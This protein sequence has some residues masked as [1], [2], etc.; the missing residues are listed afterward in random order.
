MRSLFCILLLF[1]LAAPIVGTYAGLRLEKRRVKKEVKHRLFAEV[2]TADLVFFCF[3]K[4]DKETRLR[5]E[6]DREFEFEGQM[7]DVVQESMRNDSVLLW[8]WWDHAETA[9]N[10]RLQ[11]TLAQTLSNDPGRRDQERRAVCFF[12]P[13][14]CGNTRRAPRVPRTGLFR[15]AA[16]QEI[17]A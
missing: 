3:S 4:K 1:C 13:F 17:F 7:Y 12:S 15:A 10:K 6:H 2:D 9:L 14:F 11:N 16:K 8:C 5:W